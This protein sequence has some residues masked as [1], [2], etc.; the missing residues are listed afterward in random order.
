[1]RSSS[2]GHFEI[3]LTISRLLANWPVFKIRLILPKI[4]LGSIKPRA[5]SP[6]AALGSFRVDL[7]PVDLPLLRIAP[8]YGIFYCSAMLNEPHMINRIERSP[9]ALA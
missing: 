1:M 4:D 8:C 7:V 6:L 9:L 3:F 5:Q 2:Q